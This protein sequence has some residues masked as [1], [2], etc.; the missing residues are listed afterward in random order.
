M[1]NNQEFHFSFYKNEGDIY[2]TGENFPAENLPEAYKNFKEKYPDIEPF[3][4]HNKT[5]INK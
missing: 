1:D 3:C 5:L 2:S 4:V